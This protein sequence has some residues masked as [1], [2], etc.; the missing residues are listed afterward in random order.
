MFKFESFFGTDTMYHAPGCA[1][2]PL[3]QDEP[4]SMMFL[5]ISDRQLTWDGSKSHGFISLAAAAAAAA[6]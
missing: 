1:L 2:C 4:R 6:A 3:P 5:Q